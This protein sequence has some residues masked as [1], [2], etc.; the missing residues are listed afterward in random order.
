MVNGRREFLSADKFTP[1]SVTGALSDVLPAKHADD[2]QAQADWTDFAMSEIDRMI[3]RIQADPAIVG[4][5][6][7]VRRFVRTWQ[8]MANDLGEMFG[9]AGAT[10]ARNTIDEV[11]AAAMRDL[12]AGNMEA[13]AFQSLF[14]NADLDEVPLFENALS[15][16][17]ARTWVPDGRLLAQTVNAARSSV[18]ITGAVS[19]EQ[20]VNRLNYVKSQMQNRRASLSE[21]L[22]AQE[23]QAP[24]D[25]NNDPLGIR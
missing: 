12:N 17:L 19:S 15:Y 6:G 11:R 2:L 8:G 24:S 10:Q 14:G 23:R 5:I 22:G 16:M 4:G 18:N 25:A 20:A 21:R 7:S 1:V 13:E 9:R 3:E